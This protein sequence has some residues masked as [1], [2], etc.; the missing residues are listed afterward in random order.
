MVIKDG[1][2]SSSH[3]TISSSSLS[4]NHLMINHLKDLTIH[5]QSSQTEETT[6]QEDEEELPF[7]IE[8]NLLLKTTNGKILS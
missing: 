8:L 5:Q 3:S 1:R 2:L 7:H 6:Q 4:T